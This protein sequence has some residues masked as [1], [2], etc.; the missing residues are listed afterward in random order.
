[1]AAHEMPAHTPQAVAGWSADKVDLYEINEAFAVVT[2]AAMREHKLP[3]EKVNVHGGA[4]ALGH[5]I[6]SSGC[7][8]LVSLVHAMR[9]Q[10]KNRG[11]ASLCVGVGQ[12]ISMLVE[13][14][15]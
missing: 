3:H 10:G 7:R 6:G 5:P 2:M 11:L 12:G 15:A 1:M 8:I 13:R 4:C 9:A 14:T